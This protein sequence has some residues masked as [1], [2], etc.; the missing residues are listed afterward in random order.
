[1][2][3]PLS[4]RR[5]AEQHGFR[6]PDDAIRHVAEALLAQTGQSQPHFALQPLLELAPVP[7]DPIIR[8]QDMVYAGSLTK[9]GDLYRIAVNAQ[10]NR[11]RQRFSV[12]HELG[13][14]FFIPF[15]DESRYRIPG[16]AHD[17][18]IEERMCNIFAANVLMP[19]EQFARDLEEKGISAEAVIGMADS[20]E[21][22]IETT[23]L[24]VT[25]VISETA[26]VGL[27]SPPDDNGRSHEV[28]ILAPRMLRNRPIMLKALLGKPFLADGALGCVAKLFWSNGDM[29]K[30]VQCR[31]LGG[32][33]LFATTVRP[34]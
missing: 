11:G 34:A 29:S 1:M 10:H 16:T 30:E 17:S 3:L 26:V 23:A 20:Y 25:E 5:F 9:K 28:N 24:R 12:A 6:R 4:V 27:L 32:R 33:W 13:H 15:S 31:P 21:V 19:E 7:L 2:S 14:A 22:S 8:V 18:R